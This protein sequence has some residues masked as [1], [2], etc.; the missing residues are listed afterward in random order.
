[1]Q[2][3]LRSNLK[4]NLLPRAAYNLPRVAQ[5]DLRDVADFIAARAKEY[6][7]VRTGALRD[8]IH[9]EERGR[10]FA[11]IA[12]NN[13]VDYAVFQEYGT[14]HHGPHPFMRPAAIDGMYA[15]NALV[16]ADNWE[17]RLLA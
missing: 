9:V 17:G 5:E 11:I 16:G 12:G 6:A 7:P 2:V 15:V 8:S 10:G 13:Q 3:Y 1:M 4:V 14:I